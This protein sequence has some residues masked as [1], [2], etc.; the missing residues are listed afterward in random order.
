MRSTRVAGMKEHLTV[1][2][3]HTFLMG[4]ADVQAHTLQFLRTGSF[5]TWNDGLLREAPGMV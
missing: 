3:G 5:H 1:H 4:R 2:A